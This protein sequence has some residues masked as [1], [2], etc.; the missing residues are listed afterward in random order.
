V[1]HP[2]PRKARVP[3]LAALALFG[4]IVVARYYWVGPDHGF[5]DPAIGAVNTDQTSPRR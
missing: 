4:G 2:K 3:L 1:F 5:F